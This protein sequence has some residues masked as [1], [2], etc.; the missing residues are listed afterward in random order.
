MPNTA[1]FEVLAELREEMLQQIL[2]AAWDNNLVPHSFDI[3]AGTAFGPY[4]VSDGVVNVPRSGLSLAMAPADNGVA[5]T[6]GSEI[7]VE[8]A[9]PPVPSATFFGLTADVTLTAAIAKLPGTVDVAIMLAEVP[10]DKVSAVITSGDPI[11]PITLDLIEEFVHARYQ[12]G[13]IPALQTSEGESFAGFTADVSVEMY[14]DPSEPSRRIEVSQPSATEVK[15]RIP[16]HLK[17]SN[18][19][20]PA[21]SPMGV[22][23][24]LAIT[25]D[26]E[27][28]PGSIKA[29]LSTAAV[30]VEDYQPAPPSNAGISYDNEG[31]NYSL[32]VSFAPVLETVIQA[33]LQSEAQAMAAAIG[34]ITVVVPT[35]A[36]IESFIADQAHAAVTA[37]GNINLWTPEP[38]ADGGVTVNDVV[39]KALSDAIAFGINPTGSANANAITNF[40][41]ANRSCGIAIDGAIV[42]ALIDDHIHRPESEGGFG[43]DF[44]P[45][46]FSNVD[47][48]DARLDTLDISLRTGSIHM[49]G[50]VTVI[51]AIGCIDVGADF[52]ADAGLEWKDNSDGTQRIEPFVI[53]KDVDLSLLAWILSFLIGFIT[54]GLVGGIIA[55]VI[56]AVVESV[57]EKVGG[58]VIRDEIT[59]Q[60]KGVGAWPQTIKGVGTVV[61]RFENPVVIDPDGIM[62][63]DG[64]QVTAIFA[65]TVDALARAN[66]PYSFPGGAP[67]P[68]SG[69]PVKPDTTYGWQF[70]D[71]GSAA[72]VSPSHVY[73]DSG[74]YVAK[75]TTDVHQDGGVVTREFAKVHIR[76]VPAVVDLGPPIVVNEGEEFEVV[77]KFTDQEW[78]DT[79]R[80]FFDWGDN[81]MI[82]EAVVQETNQAPQAEGSA[83]AKHAYC[84]NGTYV[85]TV[86]I[87]DDDGGLGV[88]TKTI[89]VLNVPPKVDAGPDMFAYPCTPIT[90]RACFIDPGW[91]DTHTGTWDFGDCTPP[92]PAIIKEKNEP[93]AAVGYAAAAHVYDCCGTFHAVATVVDDDGGVGQDSILVR[94]TDV[95]N[96]DF[97]HGFRSLLFGVVAN[98][99]EPY[100]FN[101]GSVG[102]AGQPAGGASGFFRAEQNVVRDGQRSQCIRSMGAERAGI[103]QHVG[104]NEGWDYQVATWFHLDERFGGTCRLGVDPTGGS[105]PSDPQV[106][107][108]ESS[109]NQRW[110]QLAVRVTA[111]GKRRAIT[112]F[113]EIVGGAAATTSTALHGAAGRA[114][115]GVCWFDAVELVPYP[116]QIEECELP[117]PPPRE[118]R[119]CVDWREEKRPRTLGTEH[120][121]KGFVFRSSGPNEPLRIVFM[122]SENHPMLSLS[123]SGIQVELPFEAERAV[124][125]VFRGTSKPIRME[126][127][128]SGTSIGDATTS[129]PP[130]GDLETLEINAF[131]MQM[132]HLRGGGGEG[133]L[134]ELCIYRGGRAAKDE[135][136]RRT[137][138]TQRSNYMMRRP[139]H[140]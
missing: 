97:E 83:A 107:W 17:M 135:K 61:S 106:V 77:A 121:K 58:A 123:R 71:G 39:P 37:E 57:A 55:L 3:A 88:A 98:E 110:E 45:K 72:V 10:R 74:I 99:W 54:V 120:T 50:D 115:E 129:G 87:L 28:Q 2:E 132:L 100:V 56:V 7:Q 32:A 51:D 91:C 18:V 117:E 105:D 24:T 79:H 13:T 84:D 27:V 131:G 16:I 114:G 52:E 113:L 11:G 31:S 8:I 130:S 85:L 66:G 103:Y 64:Y 108:A 81:S 101:A 69:G 22:L 36:Q 102:A 90:L 140:G 21:P 119:L 60:V 35:V 30:T 80:A 127:F 70:G 76:N 128:A 38:P 138:L 5:I 82:E 42:L 96:K 68:F 15:V 125:R 20:A 126:A 29:K 63:P 23:A 65:A 89:T 137:H 133:G 6:L 25:A 124:A 59:G 1:G 33:R 4:Q 136:D 53:D 95:E 109:D 41:P 118:E 49:E 134:F 43:P 111:Q 75:H 44:P 48:H 112:I 40:I 67:L 26:L 14:D 12:D 86:K 104:A 62:F 19:S 9:N 34:D 94:V 93:P 92:H 73:G 78:L 47:G 116:C 122:A 46:T 139:N